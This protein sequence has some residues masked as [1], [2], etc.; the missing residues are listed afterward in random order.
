MTAH[1][2][3]GMPLLQVRTARY[4]GLVLV[5][6]GPLL[7]LIAFLPTNVGAVIRTFAFLFGVTSASFG[8]RLLRNRGVLIEVTELGIVVHANVD[9]VSISPS[10]P[11]HSVA[12]CRTDELFQPSAG[13]CGRSHLSRGMGGYTDPCIV[14]EVRMDRNW[15]PP[16]T[17]RHDLRTQK[18]KLSQCVCVLAKRTAVVGSNQGN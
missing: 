2:A 17:L 7:V 5:L 11:V 10:L 15:P 6:A 3:S 9:G 12:A 4:Y 13:A 8:I 18:A 16:G 14:L 1:D